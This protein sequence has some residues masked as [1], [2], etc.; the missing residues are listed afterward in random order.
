MLNKNAKFVMVLNALWVMD[1]LGLAVE[2]ILVKTKRLAL[3]NRQMHEKIGHLEQDLQ[4][5]NN[6]IAEQAQQIA[7]LEEKL[8]TLKITSTFSKDDSDPA[9]EKVAEMLREIEKCFALLN[10]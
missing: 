5:R 3:V 6:K 10:R 1:E 2:S 9:R 4:T 7:E 8:V